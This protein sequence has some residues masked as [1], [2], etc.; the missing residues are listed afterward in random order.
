MTVARA[1]C[2]AAT[3]RSSASRYSWPRWMPSNTPTTATSLPS[4]GCSA[5]VPSTTSIGL[6]RQDLRRRDAGA[7]APTNA[8]DRAVGVDQPQRHVRRGAREACRGTNETTLG[9]ILDLGRRE[10]HC[11]QGLEAG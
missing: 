10:G 5:S 9:S 6:A 7:L 1:S 8:N 3:R 11:W 2:A 4:D